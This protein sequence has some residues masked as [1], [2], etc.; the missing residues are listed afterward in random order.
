MNFESA[1][2]NATMAYFNFKSKILVE[3][4]QFS[5]ENEIQ[6]L[7]MGW[8]HKKCFLNYNKARVNAFLIRNSVSKSAKSL[9]FG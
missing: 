1:K 2:N 7:T 8:E 6:L 5:S 4:M 3:L 9:N